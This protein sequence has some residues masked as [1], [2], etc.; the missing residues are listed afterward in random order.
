PPLSQTQICHA[1]EWETSIIQAAHP[2]LVTNDRPATRRNFESSFFCPD[3][4]K[5][6]RV[7]VARTLEQSASS[8]ALGYPEKADPAKGEALVTLAA[9]EVIAFVREFATW[10]EIFEIEEVR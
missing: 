2:E 1:C 10:P 5:P 7:S 4:R 8:G 6:S 3:F 9:T